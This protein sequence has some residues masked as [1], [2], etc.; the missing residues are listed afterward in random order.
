MSPCKVSIEKYCSRKDD[1]KG[2][3]LRG[4]YKLGMFGYAEKGLRLMS[5]YSTRTTIFLVSL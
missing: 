5:T 3:V 1:E 4:I 2:K